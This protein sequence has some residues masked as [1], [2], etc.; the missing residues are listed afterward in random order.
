MRVF[1]KIDCI[2]FSVLMY[3]NIIQAEVNAI[4]WSID[5]KR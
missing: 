1:I 2:E 4:N 3:R 5:F